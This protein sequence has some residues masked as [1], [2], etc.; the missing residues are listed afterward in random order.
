[1]LFPGLNYMPFPGLSNDHYRGYR[2]M[3]AFA[4]EVQDHIDQRVATELRESI[5][6]RTMDSA[7]RDGSVI[8]VVARYPDATAGFPQYAQW[9]SDM[10]GGWYSPTILGAIKVIPWAWRPRD[11]WIASASATFPEDRS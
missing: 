1:M 11:P 5:G 9:R 4:K 7:P 10:G 6:W 3:N 8:N 2:A